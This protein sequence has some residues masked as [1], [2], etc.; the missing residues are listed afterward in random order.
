MRRGWRLRSSFLCKTTCQIVGIVEV[1]A[2]AVVLFL[3]FIV[4]VSSNPVGHFRGKLEVHFGSEAI[5]VSRETS[6]VSRSRISVG[7]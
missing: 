1:V 3:F 6:D 2:V 5:F 4:V 7:H